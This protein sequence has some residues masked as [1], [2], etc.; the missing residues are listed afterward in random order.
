MPCSVAGSALEGVEGLKN[1]P[2]DGLP[3]SDLALAI[4]N[5]GARVLKNDPIPAP[6]AESVGLTEL[7]KGVVALDGAGE[8]PVGEVSTDRLCGIENRGK[9][10]GASAPSTS[11]L[12]TSTGVLEPEFTLSFESDELV[13]RCAQRP[14]T[15]STA[16][17]KFVDPTLI[18][19]AAA[20]R[21]GANCCSI[22]RSWIPSWSRSPI[23]ATTEGL[24]LQGCLQSS[25]RQSTQYAKRNRDRGSIISKRRESVVLSHTS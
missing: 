22:L 17:K 5:L 2:T 21:A 10:L 6:H 3:S 8:V 13:V 7:T 1:P 9:V 4:E 25:I 15:P 24:L 16:L 12:V 20:S 23:S 18:A 11:A 14:R 19:L